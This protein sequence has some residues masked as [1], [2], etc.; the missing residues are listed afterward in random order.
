MNQLPPIYCIGV[1][2]EREDA[3]KNQSAKRERAKNTKTVDITMTTW[4]EAARLLEK[5][6]SV[7]RRGAATQV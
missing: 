5:L 1:E 4:M 6:E 3:A 7:E 2:I